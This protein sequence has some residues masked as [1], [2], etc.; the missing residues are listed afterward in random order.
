MAA[1]PGTCLCSLESPIAA[2]IEH[3]KSQNQEEAIRTFLKV[4]DEMHP[5]AAHEMSQEE[6]EVYRKGLAIYLSSGS[7][8]EKAHS[9]KAMLEPICQK[10]P[11]YAYLRYLLAAAYANLGEF[12]LFFE[13]FYAGYKAE[14]AHFLAFKTRAALHIK[15]HD[16]ERHLEKR[17]EQRAAII[18]NVKQAIA[19]YPQDISLYKQLLF[20]S[21]PEEKREAIK[22]CL[23]DILNNAILIPKSD[24]SFFVQHALEEGVIDPARDFLE[25]A[26]QQHG[27]SRAIEAAQQSIG[28]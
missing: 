9:L 14:P 19:C 1:G 24:I 15:L 11:D 18:R 12:A 7:T 20:F 23:H 4:L 2:S 13:A 10:H 17:E 8:A 22:A 26:K 21:S 3:L 16:M 28:G 25:K 27:F 5:Q 6:E